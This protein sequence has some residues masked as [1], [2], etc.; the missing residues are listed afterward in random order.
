MQNHN[1]LFSFPRTAYITPF[2]ELHTYIHE[3]NISVTRDKETAKKNRYK[4]NVVGKKKEEETF[5]SVL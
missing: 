4:V 1:P 5:F 2:F 3:Y